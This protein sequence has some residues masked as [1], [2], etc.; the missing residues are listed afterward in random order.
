M[1]RLRILGDRN[2]ESRFKFPRKA[3]GP[4]ASLACRAHRAMVV[5]MA[6]SDP[7]RKFYQLKPKEFERVNPPAGEAADPASEPGAPR[8]AADGPVDVRE[9]ARQAAA[10]APLLG[11]NAPANRAN[12]VHAMLRENHERANAEG[13]NELAPKTRR[14]SRRKRDYIVTSLAGNALLVAAI[15]LQPVFAIAGIIL[16]NIGLTWIMWFVMDDY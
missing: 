1:R 4:G 15:W 12:D 13:L 6:E 3:D 2:G 16:F 9:M 8:A 5:R 11:G 7:P 14:A 10:G